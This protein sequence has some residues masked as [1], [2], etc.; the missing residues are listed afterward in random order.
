M[1][2]ESMQKYK[3]SRYNIWQQKTGGAYLYNTFSTGLILLDEEMRDKLAPVLDGQAGLETLAPDELCTLTENGFVVPDGI[4]ELDQ[5]KFRYLR[6]AFDGQKLNVTLVPTTQCNYACKY[7]FEQGKNDQMMSDDDC[8]EVSLFLEKELKSTMPRW[9]MMGWYGGE[10]LLALSIVEKISRE[11][12]R[13]CQKLDIERKQDWI[14]TNGYL[15][16]EEIAA[17]MKEWNIGDVQISLDGNK[18]YHDRSRVLHDGTGTFDRTME[19]I[20]IASRHFNVVR[21]RINTNRE[22]LEGVKEL[23]SQNAIF[24]K[25]NVHWSLG[26]LKSYLGGEV[27]RSQDKSYFSGAEYQKLQRSMNSY[28]NYGNLDFEKHIMFFHTKKN[29]CGADNI[30]CFYI[31]PRG[32]VYK[33]AEHID[34]EDNV[35]SIKG[36]RFLPNGRYY[37]WVMDEPFKNEHCAKCLY[38]PM[39]MGGCP[40]IRGRLGVPNDE[41]CGYWKT[42]LDNKLDEV[43]AASGNQ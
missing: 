5:V 33:C 21:L 11:V 16:T 28:R 42:W 15:L 40:A 25:P 38:L 8:E 6:G 20:E 1:H 2:G 34:Q 29:N 12:T 22:N 37:G 13:I 24:S 39:C 14:A 30:K 4:D 43:N 32:L 23:V 41:V 17:K 19:A 9:F 31:G 35:G 36:G 7:C 26:N 27:C 18:E 10:P 3:P